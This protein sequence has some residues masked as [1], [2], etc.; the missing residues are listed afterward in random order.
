MFFSGGGRREEYKCN[1][2]QNAYKMPKGLSIVPPHLDPLPMG[3]GEDTSI[4]VC[5]HC[6][7]KK[8]HKILCP[9]GIQKTQAVCLFLDV[10]FFGCH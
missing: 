1:G 7:Y 6:C 8:G 10:G 4:G 2:M 3:E 5:M 9:Y